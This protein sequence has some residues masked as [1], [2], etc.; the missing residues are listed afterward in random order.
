MAKLTN[1]MEPDEGV[2]VVLPLLEIFAIDKPCAGSRL[3]LL[4]SVILI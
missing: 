3:S 2:H 1:A 4:A